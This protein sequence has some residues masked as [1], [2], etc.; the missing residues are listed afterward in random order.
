MMGDRD[1]RKVI[2]N[3]IQSV[4]RE[5]DYKFDKGDITKI[6]ASEVTGCLRK[7][8]YDRIDEIE[9]DRTSFSDL[10]GGI[11][12]VTLGDNEAK[13]RGSQKS[14]LERKA[15]PAFEIGLEIHSKQNWVLHNCVEE[16]VDA[17]LQGNNPPVQKRS[18][19]FKNQNLFICRK[20]IPQINKNLSNLK[21]WNL[22]SDINAKRVENLKFSRKTMLK[23]KTMNLNFIF[24]YIYGINFNYYPVLESIINL[25]D[26]PIILTQEIRRADMILSVYSTIVSSKKLR[27]VAKYKNIVIHS[28]EEPKISQI[29]K[30]LKI[31]SKI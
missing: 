24:L 3:S 19:F 2:K 5:L 26:L 1:Y 23:A 28:I 7:A 29:T 21:K 18:F 22:K 31:I 4:G 25:L 14:I 13:R 15:S 17:I 11:Q 8:F 27:K 30:A 6:H 10:I 12:Y 20:N 9:A 16:A